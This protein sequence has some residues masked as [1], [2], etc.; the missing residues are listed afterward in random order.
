MK[1]QKARKIAIQ[2][3]VSQ[4]QIKITTNMMIE[5]LIIQNQATPDLVIPILVTPDQAIVLHPDQI[6]HP[7]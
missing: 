4:I 6:H 1:N 2:T 3:S 5:V 7:Q